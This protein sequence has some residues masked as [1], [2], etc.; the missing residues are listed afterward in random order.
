M[1]D[2]S[3]APTERLH[4]VAWHEDIFSWLSGIAIHCIRLRHTLTGK[5]HLLGSWFVNMG[6]WSGPETLRPRLRTTAVQDQY[7]TYYVSDLHSTHKLDYSNMSESF[8]V[9]W[10]T[11]KS[12]KNDFTR[13]NWEHLRLVNL[14]FKRKPWNKN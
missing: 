2:P 9:A 11:L 10:H 12:L 7:G 4:D 6:Q 8:G 3:L 5:F 1:F 13:I 14:Y